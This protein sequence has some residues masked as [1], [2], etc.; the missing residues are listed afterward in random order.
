MKINNA[1]RTD[2]CPLENVWVEEPTAGNCSVVW[3]Q[4]P[5]VDY[6]I[7]FIKRDDGTEKSCN[8]TRT[9]CQFFCMCGYTYLTTVFPYNQAGSSPYSHIRNYTTSMSQHTNTDNRFIETSCNVQFHDVLGSF[10]SLPVP[11]CPDNVAVNLVSTETLEVVWS[12]VKGAQLYETTAEETNDVIHCND[13]QPVCA[14][15]DLTCNTA[16]SVTVTPCS[17]LRGC[18]HTCASH[19]HETGNDRANSPHQQEKA[20]KNSHPS[21]RLQLRALRRS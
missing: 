21:V 6:Y 15:S 7:A 20:V 18:N 19:T 16:Y 5:L 1:F 13:T 3:G 12:A 11:C 9:T 10:S 8:T 4:V 14:L 17:D 2:P